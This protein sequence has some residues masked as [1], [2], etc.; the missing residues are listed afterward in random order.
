MTTFRPVTPVLRIFDV[1]KAREFYCDFLGF[2]VSWE[3]RFSEDLPLYMGLTRGGLELHLTEHHGD[4]CPGAAVRI[5]VTDIGGWHAELTAKRYTY[6]RP[7][8]E[9]TAWGTRE[10]SVTDPFGNRL[11]FHQPAAK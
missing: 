11:T 10:L 4:C 9:D 6:A 3:H 5:A 7:G 8:I 1:A 2:D